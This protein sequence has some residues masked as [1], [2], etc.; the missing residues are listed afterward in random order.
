MN[1]KVVLAAWHCCVRRYLLTT[2][3]SLLTLM[4]TSCLF[5]FVPKHAQRLDCSDKTFSLVF[6]YRQILPTIHHQ[7]YLTSGLCSLHYSIC[8]AVTQYRLKDGR[9][10]STPTRHGLEP[11]EHASVGHVM[12]PLVFFWPASSALSCCVW[13]RSVQG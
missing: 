12:F 11:D 13:T 2:K 10:L 9:R 5:V 4:L 3:A 7:L 1:N 6:N 8:Y